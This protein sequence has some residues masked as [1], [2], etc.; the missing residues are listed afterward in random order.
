VR[1]DGS[2]FWANVTITAMRD[3]S[4]TLVGYAKVTRDLS[5]RRKLEQERLAHAH[6]QEAV[7]LRDEF[8]SL[9]SHELKTPLTVLQL[10]L[11]ALRERLGATDHTVRAKLERSMRAAQRLGELVEA[12]LDVSRIATGGFVLRR[13]C[14]DMAE[15]VSIAVDRLHEAAAAA[16]CAL[17]VVAEKAIGQWD[18]SRIDQ[19]ISNLVSNAIRYA[20]GTPIE[21]S[22]TRDTTSV[23]IAVRDH[24]P[25]LGEGQLP[26][27]FERFERGVPIRHF[28][29]LGLGLYL[30]R[31]ITEAHGGSIT[32]N[33]AEG[34]GACFMVRMPLPSIDN[35]QVT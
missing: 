4:G 21:V 15:I 18:R 12:L 24:G 5:E 27:I 16:G 2:Q 20:A 9:A 33:N 13:E 25:G 1:K 19:V 26:R 17:S 14:A 31:Q 6:A 8:L 3:S 28:G 23:V 22:V 7:R 29:G 10:Q 32:A 11:D 34:G 35:P 30:V